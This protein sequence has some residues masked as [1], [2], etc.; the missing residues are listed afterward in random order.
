M[1]ID[2]HCHLHDGKYDA[3]REA[4]LLRAR[5]SG[6][7]R[8]VTVGTSVRE[9]EQAVFC[10]EKHDSVFATVGLHPHVFNGG[11]FRDSEWEEDLGYYAQDGESVVSEE[12]RR[13]ALGKSLLSLEKLIESSSEHVVAVGEIGLDYFSHDPK[14]VIDEGQR[15][16]Q[17]EG[18]L[19]QV[20]LAQ[21]HD[22]PVVVHCRDAY[23]DLLHLFSSGEISRSERVV[24]HCHMASVEQAKQFLDSGVFF[25]F[26]GNVTYSK[27]DDDEMSRVLRLVPLERMMVETDGPFLTPVPLRG[28]RNEPAYVRHVAEHISRVKNVPVGD[29]EAVTT[30]NAQ[31]FFGI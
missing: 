20:K 6:V 2:T 28:Q 16:W 17:R 19:S 25:S 9:S 12:V 27:R 18:F 29:V 22:L 14:R 26:T 31:Q 10:A 11:A 8:V 24:I 30:K 1:L 23:D 15:L 21:K 4:V 3:D 7:E 5:E 13:D